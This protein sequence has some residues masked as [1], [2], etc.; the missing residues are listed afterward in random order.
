MSCLST[1]GIRRLQT[2]SRAGFYSRCVRR[3]WHFCPGL[4]NVN[5]STY[6][7]AA[8]PR[9]L[10]SHRARHQL[11][12]SGECL[13]TARVFSLK[14]MST[15]HRPYDEKALQHARPYVCDIS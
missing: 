10:A 13:E 2:H 8:P 1:I 3:R 12:R 15:M 5:C 6:I 11:R 9:L 4:T 7:T 14:C